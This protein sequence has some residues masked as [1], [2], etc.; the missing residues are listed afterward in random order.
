MKNTSTI[1]KITL[2]YVS[3][4]FSA[5]AK[6]D[7]DTPPANA[8]YKGEFVNGAHATS[9]T[10]SIDQGETILTL[11]NFKTD[12]GPDVNIYIATSLNAVTSDYIDL[13]DI[14]G[15]NGTYTYSLPGGKDYTVYKYVIVWCVDFD[16]NF[17]YA[18]LV[19]Q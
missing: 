13:G 3:V 5:C 16:V 4:L 14:K 18:A 12:N 15:R 11:T 7:P 19:K 1:F 2:L 6:D 9:G 17:G 10:A 8:S